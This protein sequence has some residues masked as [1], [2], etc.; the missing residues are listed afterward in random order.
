MEGA[1]SPRSAVFRT[2]LLPR[3]CHTSLM[4]LVRKRG[5]KNPASSS[6]IISV[7]GSPALRRALLFSLIALVHLLLKQKFDNIYN[8]AIILIRARS[9]Y[10][11]S[12]VYE[13]MKKILL[14]EDE[15]LIR[16]MYVEKL[17]Q[18]N[19]KIF[20]ASTT[21]EAEEILRRQNIDLIILDILLPGENG[22]TYL[23]RLKEKNVGIPVIIL[24]NLEGKEYRKMAKHFQAK[25]YLLK[26]NYTPSE[27][28]AKI[29]KY[30]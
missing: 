7:F 6:T 23:K 26:T 25:K 29:K 14:V 21:L 1:G 18:E 20:E 9:G 28:L 8:N 15:K 4:C 27:I 22:L 10:D 11:N 17:R 24:S 12:S 13:N 3:S 30:L 2:S 19:V 16:E 5:Q